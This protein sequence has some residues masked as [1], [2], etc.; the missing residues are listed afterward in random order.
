M[1]RS[2]LVKEIGENS[3]GRIKKEIRE[4]RKKMC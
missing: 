3:G 4:G 1:K 2:M